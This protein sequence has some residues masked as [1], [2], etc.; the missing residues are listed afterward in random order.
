MT[1]NDNVVGTEKILL[2][3][4]ILLSTQNIMLKLISKKIFTISLN[5]R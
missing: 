2:N 5:F 4:K 1:S 3:E